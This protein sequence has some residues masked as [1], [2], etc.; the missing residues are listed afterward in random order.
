VIQ[1]N[2]PDRYIIVYDDDETCGPEFAK[3]L[4][5]RGFQNVF[6]LSGGTRLL[7]TKFPQ[8]LQAETL[9][10]VDWKQVSQSINT[11]TPTGIE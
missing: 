11:Y 7:A 1:K 10:S 5:E 9:E 6:L 2:K 3:H 4:S 8:F